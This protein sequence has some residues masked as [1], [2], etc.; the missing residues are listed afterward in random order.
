MSE[1]KAKQLNERSRRL[2]VYIH[3]YKL[4]HPWSPDIREMAAAVPSQHEKEMSTS[5]VNYYLN[6]LEKEGLISWFYLP[7]IQGKPR[8][9]RAARTVH[10][11]KKGVE[12]VN[13][14][15]ATQGTKKR[16]AEA[17]NVSVSLV[18]EK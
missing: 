10:L 16:I 6:A 4:L 3:E 17:F 2:L 9:F 13:S 5:V 18:G 1:T 7:H 15:L 12:Y 14:L 11:T 8:P